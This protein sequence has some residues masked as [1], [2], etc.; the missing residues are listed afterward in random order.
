VRPAKVI[1][2]SIRDFLEALH[3]DFLNMIAP[4]TIKEDFPDAW[5]SREP[6]N[7]CVDGD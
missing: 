3:D 1:A 6:S 2:G 5:C 7:V 4:Y